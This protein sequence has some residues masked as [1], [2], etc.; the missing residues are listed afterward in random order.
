MLCPALSQDIR[1]NKINYKL[2]L[3]ISCHFNLSRGTYY[4]GKD[5]VTP[6]LLY[7]LT[8]AQCIL[9]VNQHGICSSTLVRGINFDHIG[10]VD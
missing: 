8:F 4:C 3:I 5:A 1:R 9:K 6:I 7:E 10:I 2:Y